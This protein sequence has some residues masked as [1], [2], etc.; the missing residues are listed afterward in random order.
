VTPYAEAI[1]ARPGRVDWWARRLI[2]EIEELSAGLERMGVD[3]ETIE[4]LCI[5]YKE[6]RI[7]AIPGRRGGQP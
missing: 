5:H 4:R 2:R 7:A 3:D 1:H 6:R